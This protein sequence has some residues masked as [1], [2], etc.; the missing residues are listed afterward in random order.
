MLS[1]SSPV[2][3]SSRSMPFSSAFTRSV[4]TTSWATLTGSVAMRSTSIAPDSTLERSSRSLISPRRWCPL[5]EIVAR[6]RWRSSSLCTRLALSTSVKP[7][8]AVIGVRIS[9]LMFERKALLARF[10][11]SAICIDSRS[12]ISCSS[13][14]VTSSMLISTPPTCPFAPVTGEQ[15][16]MKRRR[17]P[18]A[19]RK[20][21]RS[22]RV[23]SPLSSARVQGIDARA[24]VRPPSGSRAPSA[25]PPPLSP[26]PPAFAS[27]SA[28]QPS[29]STGAPR[30]ASAERPLSSAK[31]ALASTSEPWRSTTSSDS[32]MVSSA[33]RTR[34]G[35]ALEGSSALSMRPR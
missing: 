3:S 4:L 22:S 16:T 28:I 12:R 23:G 8:M 19:S 11:S 7:R 29:E 17:A 9:W 32:A 31:A 34:P 1:G 30:S 35:T 14:R 24:G 25:S 6:W 5:R 2:T 10:A 33:E 13:S 15:L 26:P 27:S 18:E 21:T 20:A